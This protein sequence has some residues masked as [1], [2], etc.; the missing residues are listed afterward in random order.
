MSSI[1]L[2]LGSNQG[3]KTALLHQAI[4]LIE[5]Q[6]GK[7]VSCS[8]LYETAAWGKTNQPSFLNQ[9]VC[10]NSN[11]DPYLLLHKIQ[12]IEAGCG[13]QRTEHWGQRTMDVDI[14]FYEDIII[15]EP[16]ML[17]IPHPLIPERRF[18]LEPLA[19]IASDLYHPVLAC[20]VGELLA[21]CSDPLEVKKILV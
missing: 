18:A 5:I 14:L 10:V 12:F 1:Y 2:L 6:I 8:G 13:R 20:T 7:I 3:D 11:L 21:S 19:E 15:Q 17:I 4:R 9:V 16:P